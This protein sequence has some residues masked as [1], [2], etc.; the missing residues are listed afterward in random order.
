[1]FIGE[2]FEGFAHAVFGH[3]LLGFF[4]FAEFAD[5]EVEDFPEL[6]VVVRAFLAL[7]VEFLVGFVDVFD[8]HVDDASGLGRGYL[9]LLV[10]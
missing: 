5:E 2:E 6:F 1:M 3:F 4:E 9:I 7:V 10:V 8:E